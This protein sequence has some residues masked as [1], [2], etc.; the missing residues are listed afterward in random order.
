VVIHKRKQSQGIYFILRGSVDL[1]DPTTA[2]TY[3]SIDAEDYFGDFCLL[4]KC[5]TCDYTSTATTICL[6]IDREQIAELSDRLAR[7]D[8]RVFSIV[9]QRIIKL[10]SFASFSCSDA[11]GRNEQ[12]EVMSTKGNDGKQEPN[13]DFPIFEPEPEPHAANPSKYKKNQSSYLL[14]RDEQ[15][16]KRDEAVHGSAEDNYLFTDPLEL[17]SD[18]RYRDVP[19]EGVSFK[20]HIDREHSDKHIDAE[21]SR[22]LDPQQICTTNIAAAGEAAAAQAPVGLELSGFCEVCS[23]E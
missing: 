14:N 13:P 9:E 7:Q 20:L 23:T 8:Q 5:A 18:E 6:F 19:D 15:R 17:E 10:N 2:K 12:H 22:G 1:R 21:L 11:S 3:Y 4:Q 16:H